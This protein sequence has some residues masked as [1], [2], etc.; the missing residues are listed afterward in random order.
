MPLWLE[1]GLWGLLAGGALVLG[2]AAGYVVRLPKRVVAGVMAFGAGV[3]ISALSFEL[4][5][6]AYKQAGRTPAFVF[7]LWTTIALLSGLAALAGYA[8]FGDFS[9]ETQG[10][11]T[12]LAAGGI[13][14][15]LMDT[16]I[17][18]AFEGAHNHSGLI[19]ALGFLC[20]FA[21]SVMG[22]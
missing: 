14:A 4:V 10:A 15:M 9:A 7:G 21:L 6:E 12:A 1:A 16:M 20:A 13:L 5:L 17:P 22:G 2:A 19:A 11:T 3:L 8:V 18:E